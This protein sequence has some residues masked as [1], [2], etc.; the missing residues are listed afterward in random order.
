MSYLG[1][2]SSP[3]IEAEH[4]DREMSD[5]STI[6]TARDIDFIKRRNWLMLGRFSPEVGFSGQFFFELGTSPIVY[7]ALKGPIIEYV[8]MS[9]KGIGR[10]LSRS[11]AQREIIRRSDN[12]RIFICQSPHAARQLEAYLIAVLGPR[13][14]KAYPGKG[15]LDSIFVGEPSFMQPERSRP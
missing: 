12:I 11:H 9:K 15:L 2:E 7:V 10:P 8:G 4:P 1:Y 3:F 6:L 5:M 13:R 14:N